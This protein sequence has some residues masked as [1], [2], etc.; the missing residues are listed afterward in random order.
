MYYNIP[1]LKN[2]IY[3]LKNGGETMKKTLFERNFESV[4]REFIKLAGKNVTAIKLS[5]TFFYGLTTPSPLIEV[6][7]PAPNTKN[8]IILIGPS[9][10]GKTTYAK[11]FVESHPNFKY[12]SMDDCAIQE[13][14]INKISSSTDLYESNL[15]FSE[16]GKTLEKE[17]NL[18]IDG[19]WLPINSRSALIKTLRQL[20]F[21]TCAFSFLHY[22]NEEYLKRIQSRAI[23]NTAYHLIRNPVFLNGGSYLK[24][25]MN[26]HKLSH[27]DAVKK[28]TSTA[29]Y[30]QV[31]ENELR[32]VQSEYTDSQADFQIHNGLMYLAFNNVL[33]L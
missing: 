1:T 14:L 6:Y 22:S 16:F 18:I 28:I 7:T 11:Q 21:T 23:E 3:S 5:K 2:I 9:C 19:G 25:Y 13:A 26:I 15:G 33:I 30:Q 24:T 29:K 32:D 17:N 10:C 8:A 12:L 31:F 27:V 4:T 20:G